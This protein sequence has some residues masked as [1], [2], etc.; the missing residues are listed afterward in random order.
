MT[1]AATTWR[2]V[3]LALLALLTAGVLAAAATTAEAARAT[4]T[5]PAPK[6][7]LS[8]S[9]APYAAS[10][11]VC[12]RALALR[13]SS[14]TVGA[15]MRP[16]PG[17]RRL[18]VKV[19]LFQRPLGRGGRWTKRADV[20]GL[21]VWT[22]PSD[23]TIGTRANDLFK[24]RQAVG[25]LVVPYAY[26]FNVTFRWY[27]AAGAVVQERSAWT[28][29]CAQQDLRPDLTIVRVDVEPHAAPGLARYVLLVRN[30]GARAATGIGVG[31]APDAEGT[32]PATAVKT[33]ARLR[34]L[35]MSEVTL[36]GPRCE[37]GAEPTFAVD[38]ARTIDEADEDDN[39]LRATCPATL[40]R[41]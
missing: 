13:R 30:R 2:V 27:D 36:V 5:I 31:F 6:Q 14:A 4:R 16:I 17:G 11:I 8:R 19:D 20:P 7:T 28:P 18:A 32:V 23:A 22:T 39:A 29:A 10:L 26:R 34:P 35:E 3:G 37:P 41:P 38:P 40:Q 25:L 9:G 15:V 33:I 21:G 24:Y 12:R 1:R